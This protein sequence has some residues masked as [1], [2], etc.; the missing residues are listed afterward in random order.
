MSDHRTL[1]PQ[2]TESHEQVLLG[3]ALSDYTTA[4]K[5]ADVHPSMFLNTRFER[6]W[7][8]LRRVLQNTLD[9]RDLA[10]LPGAV[11]IELAGDANNDDG[12]PDLYELVSEHAQDAV[13]VTWFARRVREAYVRRTAVGMLGEAET[14]RNRDMPTAELLGGVEARFQRLRKLLAGDRR[15]VEL[16]ADWRGPASA[17]EWICDGWLGY[18]L[19]LFT[20]DGGRGKS[21]IA[22]QLAAAIAGGARGSWLPPNPENAHTVPPLN[23]DLHGASVL[24]VSWEDEREEVHRRLEGMAQHPA[25]P[26]AETERITDRLHFADLAGHGPLWEMGDWGRV[27]NLT[28]TGAELRTAAERIKARLLVIDP[29]AAA[30]SGNENDRAHVRAFVSD[31]DRWAREHRCAVLLV[32]HRPK[33]KA[34]EKAAT[35]AGSTDWH[36]AARSQWTLDDDDGVSLACKKSNYGPAPAPVR[37]TSDDGCSWIATAKTPPESEESDGSYPPGHVAP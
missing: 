3:A 31:W 7:S 24:V 19:T 8:A 33:A 21:R 20:G 10:N 37:L 13:N 27:G 5:V 11:G 28:T 30:F 25:L 1:T 17:R 2:E 6:V 15:G 4:A 35:Y 18:R 9:E 12:T 26:W 16:H 29:R 14:E 36:N 23:V 22:L 34:S 32:D